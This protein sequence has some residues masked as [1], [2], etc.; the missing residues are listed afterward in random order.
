M[1]FLQPLLN[2]SQNIAR[3][4]LDSAASPVE[5]EEY[6]HQ[7]ALK[8]DD[9]LVSKMRDHLAQTVLDTVHLFPEE[10]YNHIMTV[11][12]H[13]VTMDDLKDYVRENIVRPKSEA[14]EIAIIFARRAFGVGFTAMTAGNG[15]FI[16]A[17]QFEMPGPEPSY[18]IFALNSGLHFR[19]VR[20]KPD[21]ADAMAVRVF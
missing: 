21:I 20:L 10:L 7:F 4:L 18:W 12:D 17:D 3:A 2:D 9:V 1:A 6:L 11:A 5:G 19:D 13:S 15:Q 16:F 14:E 8:Y